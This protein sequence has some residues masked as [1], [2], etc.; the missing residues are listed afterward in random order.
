MD[1]VPHRGRA[2]DDQVG[3]G[4]FMRVPSVVPVLVAVSRADVTAVV[5]GVV[6]G[7]VR[8][9]VP[10]CAVAR[11]VALQTAVLPDLRV[12]RLNVIDDVAA[13]DLILID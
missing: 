6:A 3:K 9:G 2:M 11:D 13:T 12:R 7:V 1:G 8:E 10:N 4:L 5:R